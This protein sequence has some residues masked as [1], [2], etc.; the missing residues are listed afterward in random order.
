[1]EGQ[2]VAIYLD[3]ENLAISAETVYPSKDKPLGIAPIVDFASS[4]GNICLRKA[5]ADWSKSY[6]S[7]YQSQLMEHGFELIHLPETSHQ[8][9]NGSDV[10]LAVDVMEHLVRY[11]EVDTFLIGSGDTDFIPLIQRVRSQSKFVVVMGFEHSVSRLVRQNSA[12]FRSL[13]DLLGKPEEES[14]GSDLAEEM[15]L[16]YG[17]ELLIRYIKSRSEEDGVLLSKLKQHLLRMDPAFS[18]KEMGYASFKKFLKALEGDVVDR[19]DTENNTLP[20]VYFKD[21]IPD[22]APKADDK[23]E[24]A[25]HFL[26]KKLRYQRNTPQR[27]KLSTSLFELF[28]EHACI[29]M[30]EMF[31]HLDEHMKGL[32]P[33]TEIRKYINTLFTGGAFVPRDKEAQGPLLSRP[34]QLSPTI[35]HPDALDQVYI[36]RVSEILQSRYD[37]LGSE[38]IL[39]L[40]VS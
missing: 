32:L 18:E 6:F 28:R 38:E 4:K 22:Q 12:E 21:V 3:F 31:D 27:M 1:M 37:A 5:Y 36:R 24:T 34:F 10:R 16:S 26:A 23:L 8:G 15:E 33:R 40:L 35:T 14:P 20:L 9:K 29:S 39:E 25:R 13:E 19:I 7:R 30:G 11:P 2:N 17:R